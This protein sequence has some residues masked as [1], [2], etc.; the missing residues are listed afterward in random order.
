MLNGLDPIIIFQFG[1]KLFT[2]SV[3][4]KIPVADSGSTVVPLPPI[5][6]YLSEKLTGV[7][8]DSEEKSVE[9]ETKTDSL[10][11]GGTET[12]QKPIA[13]TVK[14]NMMASRE[15]L[16]VKLFAAMSDLILP[17]L[18]SKE[19]SIT[20]MHDAVVVLEGLLH[21]FSISQN[22]NDDRY[23]IAIEL[24]KPSSEVKKAGPGELK[25]VDT[26]GLTMPVIGGA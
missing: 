21:S 12:N 3:S 15:S 5:P 7:V 2:A 9:I 22:S 25:K 14:I 8:I 20:Y 13:S 19:Y 1:T 26:I 24:I 6:I 10:Q 16:G 18:A 4:D 23:L 11:S 17:K